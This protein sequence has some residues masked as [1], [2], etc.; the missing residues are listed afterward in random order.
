M[1]QAFSPLSRWNDNIQTSFIHWN[2]SHDASS[3]TTVLALRIVSPVTTA[4]TTSSVDASIAR[5]NEWMSSC[6]LTATEHPF[7]AIFIEIQAYWAHPSRHKRKA[8]AIVG[9]SPSEVDLKIARAAGNWPI[10]A[11]HSGDITEQGRDL[12]AD[13]PRS[14]GLFSWN[15][16]VCTH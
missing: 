16:V 9:E 6:V 10:S 5:D 13:S 1:S 12:P 11:Q 7:H 8:A 14:E 2:L 3:Y 4:G 15:T